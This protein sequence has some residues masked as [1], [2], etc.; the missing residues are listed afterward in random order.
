[1]P[2]IEVLAPVGNRAMLEAALAAGADAVYL[3]GKTGNARAFAG[4]FTDEEVKQ[5]IQD[6]HLRGVKTYL[7]LN[8]LVKNHEMDEI[9][10]F[11]DA[12]VQA[13]IDA[14]IL[15]DMGLFSILK[16][17]YPTLSLHASTQMNVHSLSASGSKAA[18]GS[19]RITRSACLWIARAMASFCF[20]PPEKSVASS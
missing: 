6:C 4:N 13:D 18:V 17:R 12:A 11:A 16:Q 19:S 14:I 8:T 9:L 20:C 10:D 7:T 15:Q 3:G 5:A 2:K 1:M